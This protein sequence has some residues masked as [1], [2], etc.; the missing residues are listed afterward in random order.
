[1]FSSKCVCVGGGGGEGVFTFGWYQLPGRERAHEVWV[2]TT[3]LEI[4][5]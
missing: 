5:F 2:K 1:M 4:H 3:T